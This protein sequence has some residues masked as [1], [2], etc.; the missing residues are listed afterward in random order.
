MP[1]FPGFPHSGY[2]E[3]WFAIGWSDDFEP[4][5]AHPLKYFG[6]D[7]VAYRGASGRLVV[8]DAAGPGT[9]TVATPP[10]R[11]VKIR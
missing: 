10:F 9:L 8:M 7:L 5:Q 6:E 1:A 3:G 4:Q 2:P 11:I